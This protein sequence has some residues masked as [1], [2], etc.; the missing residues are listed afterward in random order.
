MVGKSAVLVCKDDSSCEQ[1]LFAS[2]TIC[3]NS[4]GSLMNSGV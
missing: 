4:N 2:H 3:L 1:F